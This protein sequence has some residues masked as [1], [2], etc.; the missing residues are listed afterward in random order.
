M[1]PFWSTAPNELAAR[2][3]DPGHRIRHL[4]IWLAVVLPH[5]KIDPELQA[6]TCLLDT[7][8]LKQGGHGGR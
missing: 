6:A 8:E 2:S 7:H 3:A 5:Q 4:E 1:Q